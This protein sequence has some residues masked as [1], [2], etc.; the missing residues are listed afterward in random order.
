MHKNL[1]PAILCSVAAP[2]AAQNYVAIPAT[3]NVASELP[4]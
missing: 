1:L 4:N 3:A 2:L